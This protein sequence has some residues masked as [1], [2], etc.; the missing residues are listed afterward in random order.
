MKPHARKTICNSN[1]K[2]NKP[3]R[4]IYNVL[5]YIGCI[6]KQNEILNW[7]IVGLKS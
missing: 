2:C 4:G 6:E 5:W 3:R 1:V 7:R